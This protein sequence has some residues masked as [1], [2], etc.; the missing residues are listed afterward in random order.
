[1]LA[2]QVATIYYNII[3]FQ[4]SIEIQDSII[5]FLNDNK[6]IVE[7]KLRNGDAIRVDLLNI[8]AQVDIETNRKVDFQNSL[9]KQINLLAYTTGDTLTTRESVSILTFR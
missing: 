3:F 9:Q 4:K 6:K 5:V 1:M 2:L 8:Q 7:S